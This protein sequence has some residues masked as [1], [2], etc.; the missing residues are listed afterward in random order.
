TQWTGVLTAE[1]NGGGHPA[2]LQHLEFPHRRSYNTT[3]TQPCSYSSFTSSR[4]AL[5]SRKTWLC[6]H[7]HSSKAL[8]SQGEFWSPV[9]TS[10]GFD[11]IW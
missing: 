10:S 5:G 6:L 11:Q 3:S 9:T 2:M 8:R 1:K 4:K 7:S